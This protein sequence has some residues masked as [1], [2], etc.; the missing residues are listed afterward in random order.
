MTVS[1][2]A[3]HF[4]IVGAGSVGRR[5]LRNL[6]ALGCRVSAV[7]PRSDRLEEARR[8]GVLEAAYQ[9]WQAG[10]DASS[11]LGG[12]VIGSPPGFH[13]AQSIGALDRGL[14]VL[15]EKPVS[16]DAASADQ[17]RATVERTGVPLLLGYTYRW[18]PALIECR[19]RLLRGDIG[20]PRHFRAV[21]SAHLADWHPWERYQDFFMASRELGGGALLDESHF[22][23][24]LYWMFGLPQQV[25]SAVE[26]L[27]SLEIDSD[28]NVDAVLTYQGGVRASLHL[29]L[30]GRPHQREITIVGEEG[31]LHWTFDPNRLRLGRGASQ[32]EDTVYTNDRNDMF[33]AV[34]REFVEVAARRATPSCTIQDGCQVMSVLEAMRASARAGATVAMG[35]EQ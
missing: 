16:P 33:L 17:L 21:L 29:D 4:L 10:L 7:D 23:D 22:V 11:D 30:Y 2:P 12:V 24:L 27:S 3:P 9:D 15:L 28:D 35:S 6:R 14:P 13:V 34:A 5:H 18:W 8:E 26:K 20:R 1:E 25:F 32:W 19:R 31:S